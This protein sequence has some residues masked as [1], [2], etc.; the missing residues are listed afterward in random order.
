MLTAMSD[1]YAAFGIAKAH[2]HRGSFQTA[3]ALKADG[4]EALARARSVGLL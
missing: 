2:L 3:W 1:A 4:D